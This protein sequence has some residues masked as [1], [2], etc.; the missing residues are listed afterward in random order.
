MQEGTA[1]DGQRLGTLLPVGTG[2]GC[3][4]DNPQYQWN[5]RLAEQPECKLFCK[6]SLQ[7]IM[8]ATLNQRIG[9]FNIIDTLPPVSPCIVHFFKCH[10]SHQLILLA[11]FY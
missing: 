4:R 1:L 3:H 10:L 2:K 11:L 9:V 8:R 7:A 6:E 5:A